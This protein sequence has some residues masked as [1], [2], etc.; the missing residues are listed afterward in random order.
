MSSNDQALNGAA[1]GGASFWVAQCFSTA[2]QMLKRAALAA[3]GFITNKSAISRTVRII[4][5]LSHQSPL[6]RIL[7]NV[8]AEERYYS[9][10]LT[11]RS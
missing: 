4:A 10:S 1:S 2:I 3:E 11:R 6:H 8:V 7:M 9:I 5:S